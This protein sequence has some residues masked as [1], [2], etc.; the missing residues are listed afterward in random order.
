MTTKPNPVGLTSAELAAV[1]DAPKP[2]AIDPSYWY[3]PA[4]APIATLR[5]RLA[6]LDDALRL[7]DEALRA[8]NTATAL[9]L[10][11]RALGGRR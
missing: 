3:G 4:Q 7:I 9:A 1:P 11:E 6:V 2:A 8:G 5:A 10:V